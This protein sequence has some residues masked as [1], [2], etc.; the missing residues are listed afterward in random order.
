MLS[1]SVKHPTPGFTII[2]LLTVVAIIIVLAALGF[3]M[4]GRLRDNA[5]MVANL[6]NLRSLGVSLKG[7][8]GDNGTMPLGY[9][10]GTGESWASR[11]VQ[12]HTEGAAKQDP[13][14][15]APTVTRSIPPDFNHET[16]SNYAV[17]P[18]M[19]PDNRAA[20][21][22]YVPRYRVN[23]YNLGRPHEQI[24]LGDSLP[25]SA[26]APY[27]HSWC[28]WW[29]L[30]GAGSGNSNADPPVANP[31]LAERKIQFP[32]N[33]AELETDTRGYPGFRN[34]GKC[35][36]LFADGHAEGLKPEQVRQKHFAISY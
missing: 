31:A 27:G 35:H 26:K 2:E 14:V 21:S 20:G 22:D 33:I 29:A 32:A 15:L 5:L 11:V 28:L 16:I 36:F 19:F 34:K 24:L 13:I 18:S 6:Q 7:I 25:R 4:M 10:W 12:L 8:E 3:L 30:R 17:S 9:N 23:T 1:K